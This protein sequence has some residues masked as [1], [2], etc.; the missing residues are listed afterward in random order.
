MKKCR[1]FEIKGVIVCNPAVFGS[2]CV[3]LWGFVIACCVAPDYMGRAMSYVAFE[4][5][6][7]VWTWLYIIS[8]NIWVL[9]LLW[10]A[11]KHGNLKLGKDDDK[12]EFSTATWFSMLFCAGL[13]TGLFYF[14]VAEPIWHYTGTSRFTTAGKGY[15]NDNEDATRALVI[16]LYH[17]G[18]HGW[19]PYTVMGAILGIMTYRRGYPMTVRYCFWPIIGDACYGWMGDVVDALSIITSI[20]GVCTSLG[21]GAMQLNT[22]FQRLSHGNYRGVNYNI[23]NEP[24]FAN[25]GCGG[26]GQACGDGEEPYGIQ[27]TVGVQTVIILVIT[28]LATLS[29]V[30]G[31]KVGIKLLSQGVFGLGMFLMLMVLLQGEKWFCLD[32]MVQVLGF[33]IWDIFRLGH[34]CDAFE[35]LGG[36][37]FGL[38]GATDGLG[39]SSG[40]LSSW[41]LFYWGWWI[42][43]GP[44]VGTFLAK[45]SKGRTLR[46]FVMATMIVPTLFTLF[47]FGTFGSEGIR[48]QRQA[49]GSNL[50]DAAGDE[51]IQ[52]TMPEGAT[53]SLA[54]NCKQYGATY[55]QSTKEASNIGWRPGCVLDPTYHGGFG[56]C[57]PFAWSRY[58]PKGEG[59][60][61]HTSWINTPCGGAADATA[62]VET[63]QCKEKATAE[64]LTGD[65]KLWNHFDVS[66]QQGCFVPVQDGVTCLKSL[67][68]DAM[69]YD[70]LASYGP[71]GFS[72]FLILIAMLCITLYFV[73]SSDSGS[74]V[75]DI[76]SANG[77]PEPPVFQRI[78]WA[79]TEGTTAIA[80]LLAG[81]NSKNPNAS[82]KALQSASLIC[83]L[84]Y[85]F[86]LFFAT[87]SLYLAIREETGSLREDRRAFRSFIF[88][89]AACKNHVINLVA[90]GIQ[91]GRAVAECGKWPGADLGKDKVKVLWI[92]LFSIAYYSAL[93]FQI[94]GFAGADN[95]HIVG[96]AIYIGFGFLCGL[97]RT[98]VRIRYGIQH[99]DLFSDVLCG[100]FVPMFTLSQIQEQLDFPP[101]EKV[102]D[103]PEAVGNEAQKKPGAQDEVAQQEYL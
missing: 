37:D 19:I 78:F 65:K 31:L 100:V 1:H 86:I 34:W 87:L 81:S 96:G 6:P 51:T 71:R 69:L 39:G 13:A 102:D 64:L 46:E 5:V 79:F 33:Y 58:E 70:T 74:L 45:I 94:I 41:T 12:P 30:L 4:W 28:S 92:V 47:W 59:C 91:L 48:L 50:C 11:I 3:I 42:S 57:K 22:G 84:P 82:L 97:V 66:L 36:K 26:I 99:G 21:L 35:R 18:V 10:A 44:F 76:L 29:V 93:I 43:W 85:T 56:R 67:S 75:V 24:K 27:W 40:W 68:S 98:D 20:C 61:Y 73:T 89:F 103:P 9:V 15:G 38:G 101:E 83:G 72:D 55:S 7:E 8:Q 17:W 60:V 49:T 54:G 88:N 52:C 14:S 80:L 95:W 2:S 77:H 53:G 25:P 16:T 62:Y 32:T 90:P 23:P 63:P